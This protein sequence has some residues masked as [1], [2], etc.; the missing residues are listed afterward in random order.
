[1]ALALQAA[2]K[3]RPVVPPGAAEPS[4]FAPDKVRDRPGTANV[5]DPTKDWENRGLLL[6]SA[7]GG[8]FVTWD[9][10]YA[11]NRDPEAKKPGAPQRPIQVWDA[12]TGKPVGAPIDLEKRPSFNGLALSPDGKRLAA[13]YRST[14]SKAEP[15]DNEDPNATAILVRVWDTETGKRIGPDMIAPRERET[16]PSVRFAAFGRLVVVAA[17][18]ITMQ[19]T[20][21]VFDTETG[22]L[23]DLPTA[24]RAVHGGPED[25][26]LVT[27]SS[28]TNT[29][30]RV[31]HLRDARTLAVVGRPFEVSELENAA[32]TA[33][34]KRVV[35]AHSYW[36]GA[37]D[38]KT[39]ERLHPR[40][41][42]YAGAQCLAISA[43]GS[44]FAAGYRDGGLDVSFGQRPGWARVWDAATGDAVSPPIKTFGV[45]HD[46]R[47]L[48]EGRALLTV[49]ET[50]ARLWDARSG[51]P[52]TSP[53]TFSGYNG[54]DR[55]SRADARIV[56]DALLVR[57]TVQTSQYDRWSLAADD[58]PVAELHELAEALA[59]RRRNAE[60]NLQPIPPDELFA[61]RKRLAARFPEH[62][63]A[64]VSS[65]DAVLT[66]RPDPRVKQ[67]AER[68]ADPRPGLVPRPYLASMLGSLQD[69]AGQAPL[70]A[71]LGDTD[72]EV[73]R[74]AASALGSFA[75]P[76]PETVRALARTLAADKD[77]FA[78]QCAARSLHGPAKTAR[79]DLLQALKG[80]RAAGVRGGAAYA[81]RNA[82]A[83]ADL[84]AA[85]RAASKEGQPWEVRVEA[86]MSVAALAPAD[87][88]SVGVLSAAL[89]GDR[90]YLA[91]QYLNELGPRAA[92]AAAALTKVV[93]K[94]NYQPN[95]Y[96]ATR[97]AIHALAKIGPAAKPALPALLAKLGRDESNP[98]L[99]S[100]P[101]KY[102]PVRDNLVAYAL[103][104][105]GPDV[106]PDLLKVFK[107]DK[108]AKRRRSAVLALG[109][110]GP[111]AKEAVADL[112]AEAKKLADKE[113]KLRDEQWLATALEMALAR[114]RDPNAIPVEK[115][116]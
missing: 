56:G 11:P 107:E 20:Q 58:R 13:V 68:L 79:A 24:A 111:P 59:G 4:R 66:Y 33:D 65:A 1:V 88:D 31:A 32:A 83:D 16:E 98:N 97:N 3:L 69:P 92:P 12:V 63:G 106:V 67:L 73:R 113:G 77:D 27:T 86:A 110:L 102:V 103:A 42:V 18:G 48:A 70:V 25:P 71:A 93:E 76:S 57:R 78:R 15:T 74:S 10:M 82:T 95:S 55:G 44:R 100:G 99:T 54:F 21:T 104:R 91:A 75:P 46:I 81:L 8:R 53:L 90:S 39:G 9:R 6:L 41:W 38:P 115:I 101:A 22:K 47:F 50:E 61:L 35:L 94:G 43:D 5:C 36:L 105:I 19:V 45:S 14:G 96:N 64:P 84:L 72:V 87:T 30:G 60:A 2:P 26:F 51:E 17:K 23:L 37:W 116:D 112:E 89:T 108:D 40:F 85:L 28:A 34:G 52:L 109:F 29:K 114:I 49:T 62:F 7:D 80:D